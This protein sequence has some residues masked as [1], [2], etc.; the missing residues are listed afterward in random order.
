MG[1]VDG[2]G[3]SGE[4]GELRALLQDGLVRAGLTEDRL[5]D[6]TGLEPGTVRAA[7]RSGGG[8]PGAATV[9]V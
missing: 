4:L 6:R 1:G 5:A 8:A 3:G 2:G 7:L 9:A